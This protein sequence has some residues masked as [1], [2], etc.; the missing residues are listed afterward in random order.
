MAAR[1]SRSWLL[2]GS[3]SGPKGRGGY[4]TVSADLRALARADARLA[5]YQ[6][7][8]LKQRAQRAN[9]EGARLMVVPMRRN[10]PKGATGNLRRSISARANRLKPGEMAAATVGTRFKIARHRHLVVAGTEPHSLAAKRAGKGRYSVLPTTGAA[11]KPGFRVRAISFSGGRGDSQRVG[12]VRRNADLRH[13]GSRP[14]PFVERVTN[15][16][17]GQVRSF[18][19]Q[20][21]QSIG[22]EARAF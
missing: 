11:P 6:G 22:G 2:K 8:P 12:N 15:Q 4:V 18:I 5:K 17:E 9:L 3:G 13:P 21:V 14:N 1:N 19:A 10:A 7:R 16:M 20:R